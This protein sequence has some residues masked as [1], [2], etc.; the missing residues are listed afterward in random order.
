MSENEQQG[1]IQL[2]LG[3]WA[4]FGDEQEQRHNAL[5][6]QLKR[7]VP[8]HISPFGTINSGASPANPLLLIANQPLSP[9][10]GRTW[11]LRTI[12][13][14]GSDEHTVIGATSAASVV[15]PITLAASATAMVNNNPYTVAVTVA[16][17]TVS[18]IAINGTTTGLTSGTFYVPAGGTITVTYTVAPTTFTTS[19]V[20]AFVPALADLYAGTPP[21]VQSSSQPIIPQLTDAI[22]GDSSFPQAGT[23]AAIPFFEKFPTDGV[24]V[25]HGESLY[26]LVYGAPANT[27][28]T[29]VANVE[30]WSLA[31]VEA[32]NA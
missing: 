20:A 10:A 13:I 29:M 28:I 25:R 3:A 11:H 23:P 31:D 4:K 6:G 16:G 27:T 26:A 21:S 1:G 7:P 5:M 14:Y 15:N 22:S 30:D 18:A 32:L 8:L 12:G 17:G 9:A 2:L 19:Q 24:W